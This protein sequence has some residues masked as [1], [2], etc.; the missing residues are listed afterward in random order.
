MAD[1]RGG[2]V[3]AINEQRAKRSNPIS[4][5]IQSGIF[6]A[7]TVNCVDPEGRG[8]IAAYVPKLGQTPEQPDY[9]QYASPFGGSNG[10]D[11]YGF[12]A[13]PPDTG[14]TIMVFY[15][16][17]GDFSEGYWFAC[18]QTNP[19]IVSGGAVDKA[20][21]DGTGQ[22]ENDFK[23]I[24]AAK[25]IGANINNLQI[26]PEDLPN[27]NR[28]HNVNEQGLL[29]DP[30]RGQSTAT[31]RRDANYENPK[32]SKVY[33]ICTPGQT[34][35]TMDD[36]SVDDQGYVHPNQIRVTTGSGTSLILDGTNDFIY[37]VNKSGTGWVEIGA[38][39]NIMMYG[40]GSISMRAEKD[41][42]I[43]AGQNINFEAKN[44]I[45]VKADKDIMVQ[46]GKELHLKSSGTSYLQAD[47]AMNISVATNMYATTGGLM[48][49]NG[50]AAGKTK[51]LKLTTHHDIK[52]LK[53]TELKDS[54]VSFLP[55][56]EPCI[57]P[58]KD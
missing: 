10:V 34:A 43:H 32:A 42:N 48:H 54:N 53:S 24:P 9:F 36:G 30:H 21:A 23:D 3:D 20:K 37:M 38:D 18:A 29:G 7:I 2:I 17:N 11:N 49:L 14:V 8:R 31:P 26:D 16:D 33:G 44:E 28:N 35:I 12:F 15:A 56:H 25:S 13:V 39:G 22:G 57:R 1:N 46:T 51:D 45:N 5:S 58:R 55:T 47:G 50:P 40:Q 6:R 52:N 27:S 19:N 41:F 4:S